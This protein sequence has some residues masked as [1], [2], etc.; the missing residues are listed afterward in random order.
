MGSGWEGTPTPQ[1]ATDPTTMPYIMYGKITPYYVPLFSI[2]YRYIPQ[3]SL[4]LKTREN[5]LKLNFIF[6][7][8]RLC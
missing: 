5:I 1:N 2:G 7:H 6:F 3:G 8:H 4:H